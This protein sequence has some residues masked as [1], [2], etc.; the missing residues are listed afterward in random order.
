[1]VEGWRKY[2]DFRKELIETGEDYVMRDAIN[3]MFRIISL[4]LTSSRMRLF[5]NVARMGEVSVGGGA[6]GCSGVEI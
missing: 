3:R 4:C 1:M 2:V 5:E 6:G